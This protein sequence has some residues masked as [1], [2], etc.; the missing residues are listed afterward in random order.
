ML[1][2]LVPLLIAG[3]GALAGWAV[4]AV[5][6]QRS[7]D[8]AAA[9][10]RAAMIAGALGGFAALWLRDLL[11]VGGL[12]GSGWPGGLIATLLGGA[13][14]AVPIVLLSRRR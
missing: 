7:P 9:S 4:H 1:R 3:L 12:F 10:P 13:V 6:R 2:V 11:D 8:T 5:L 14:V